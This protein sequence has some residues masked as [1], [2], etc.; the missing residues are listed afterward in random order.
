MKARSTSARSVARPKGKAVGRRIEG[1]RRV[2]AEDG[3]T[4]LPVST[5]PP[6]PV[7]TVFEQQDPVVTVFE[8]DLPDGRSVAYPKR[9]GS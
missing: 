2:A 8:N 5:E 1:V 3:S 7:V 4:Y 6:D 9:A